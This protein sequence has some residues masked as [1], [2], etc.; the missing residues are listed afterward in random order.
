MFKTKV[1][2]SDIKKKI[3]AFNDTSQDFSQLF[4]LVLCTFED[5][6]TCVSRVSHS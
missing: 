1:N 2:D 6:K 5:M 3:S 4:S